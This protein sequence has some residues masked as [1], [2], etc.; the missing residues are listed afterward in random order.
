MEDDALSVGLIE[1]KMNCDHKARDVLYEI[2]F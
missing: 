2:K 1:D